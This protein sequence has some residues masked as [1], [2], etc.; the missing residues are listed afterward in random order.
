MVDYEVLD[1][2]GDYAYLILRGALTG[3]VASERL[4]ADLERHYVDDG[5]RTIRVELSHL[6]SITLEGIAILLELWKESLARD[7]RFVVENPQA[8][9]RDKLLVTG[10][11]GPLSEM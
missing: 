2:E 5:V 6:E 8:Q 3:D 4:K 10:L 11:L 7:K 1:R 9:V